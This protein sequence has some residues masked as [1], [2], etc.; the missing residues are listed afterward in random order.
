[1][2]REVTA[3]T[4]TLNV[5]AEGHDGVVRTIEI[6]ADEPTS[7]EVRLKEVRLDVR[8]P[9]VHKHRMGRCEGRLVAGVDGL[10]Y[11]TAN[12]NDGFVLAFGDVEVFEV[13]YLEKNLRVK[14]RGG[15]TW[16]FTDPEGQADPLFVFHRDVERARARLGR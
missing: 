7:V 14:Q 8:I 15:R 10:R 16:N 12:A 2:T 5:S 11:E 4:K 1:M 3:G 9:V 6:A 13:D